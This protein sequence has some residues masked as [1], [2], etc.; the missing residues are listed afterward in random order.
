M[1]IC[2]FGPV[3]MVPLTVRSYGIFRPA[4]RDEIQCSSTGCIKKKETFRNQAYC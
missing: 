4:C 1:K 2:D 3:H